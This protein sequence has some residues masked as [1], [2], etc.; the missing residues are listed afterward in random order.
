MREIRHPSQLKIG[1][2]YFFKS[3]RR[4]RSYVG[5]WIS[6]RL[7]PNSVRRYQFKE[8]FGCP[9]LGSF[10][11]LSLVLVDSTSDIYEVS[12]S[13]EKYLSLFM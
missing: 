3:A 12:G 6:W 8:I 1:K 10:Y 7:A 9:E 13:F 5:S 11:K 2:I 4:F